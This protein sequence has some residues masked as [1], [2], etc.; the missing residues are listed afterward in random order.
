MKKAKEK[1]AKDPKK[2]DE[3]DLKYE[4]RE[5]CIVLNKLKA[6]EGTRASAAYYKAGFRLMSLDREL[7]VRGWNTDYM[8]VFTRAAKEKKHERK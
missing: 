4:I 6:E 7:H 2:M 3:M 5:L 8:P 1:K